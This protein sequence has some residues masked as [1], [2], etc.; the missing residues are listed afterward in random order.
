MTDRE[1]RVCFLQEY[2]SWLITNAPVDNPT[3][4]YVLVALSGLSGF[5]KDYIILEEISEERVMWGA[6][7]LI[8]EFDQ[9][10]SNVYMKFS[11][12]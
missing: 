3:P 10:T 9:K 2:G 11:I 12:S 6:G 5:D 1:K 4:I 8:S 7:G